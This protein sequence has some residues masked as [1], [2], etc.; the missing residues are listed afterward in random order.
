MDDETRCYIEAIERRFD[1]LRQADQEAI[2][3][4]HSELTRRMEGFPQEFARKVEVAEAA[5]A[6]QKLERDSV[7]REVY[8]TNHKALVDLVQK[9]ERTKMD[10]AV[11]STFVE[12]YR[13]QQDAASTER[14]AVAAALAASTERRAGAQ[15]ART[16]SWTQIAA[17]LGIVLTV[18]TIVVI[19]ANMIFR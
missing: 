9:L 5:K 12:N 4:R 7:A 6:L 16:A 14:R 19:V 10:E 3:V 18:M 8:D 15:E 11:F 2:K 17:L 1:A 13:I